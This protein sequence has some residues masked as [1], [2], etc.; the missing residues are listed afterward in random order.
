MLCIALLVRRVEELSVIN[1][2]K[3]GLKIQNAWKC[4]LAFDTQL[5]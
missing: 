3:T 5:I 1:R 2:I 4:E